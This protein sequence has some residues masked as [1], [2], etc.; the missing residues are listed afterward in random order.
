MDKKKSEIIRELK[1]FKAKNNIDRII[2]FGSRIKK[3]YN[4]YSDV[5]LIV[6]SPQFKGLKSFKRAP[7]IRLK[8]DLDYPIDMLCFTPKEFDDK[9]DEPTIVR[10]AV[11]EGIEI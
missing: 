9:K 2:F 11:K 8:L 4:K 1:K 5:D 7:T 10:E 6:V 3:R